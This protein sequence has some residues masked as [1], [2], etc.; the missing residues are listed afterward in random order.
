MLDGRVLP[1]AKGGGGI[2]RAEAQ[3][4]ECMGGVVGQGI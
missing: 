2:L 4:L 1:V 3:E